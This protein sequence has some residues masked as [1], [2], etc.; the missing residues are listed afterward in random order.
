MFVDL[1]YSEGYF[2]FQASVYKGTG[3]QMVRFKRKLFCMETIKLLAQHCHCLANE[4]EGRSEEE[5]RMTARRPALMWRYE[6]VQDCSFKL[7]QHL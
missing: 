7:V 3:H 5:D 6:P 4:S 1:I 2:Q